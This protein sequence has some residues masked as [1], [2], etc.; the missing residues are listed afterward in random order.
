MDCHDINNFCQDYF[1]SKAHS[2]FL[3]SKV[4][5]RYGQFLMNYFTKNYPGITVPEECDC[6]YDDKKVPKFFDFIASLESYTSVKLLED[7]ELM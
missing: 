1:L 2:A 4:N 7:N 5:Q 6:F 3:H